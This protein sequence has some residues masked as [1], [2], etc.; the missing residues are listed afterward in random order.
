MDVKSTFLNGV[1]KEKIYIEQPPSYE[2]VGKEHKVLKLKKRLYG[3]KQA[4]RA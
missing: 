3:L 1:F 2:K 4:S